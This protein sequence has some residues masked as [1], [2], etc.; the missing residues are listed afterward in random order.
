MERAGLI[1]ISPVVKLSP[2]E[3]RYTQNTIFARFKDGRS[4][5]STLTRLLD[6]ST[7]VDSIENFVFIERYG[8]YWALSGNRRLHLYK[9]LHKYGK[10]ASNKI[11]AYVAR[12]EAETDDWYRRLNMIGAP[13]TVG[14]SI[15]VQ[16]CPRCG[17][18]ADITE[19][20]AVENNLRASATIYTE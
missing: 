1:L 19:L 5:H 7:S 9:I 13:P 10:L 20:T 14:G 18:A 6:E 16:R 3:I 4:L 12:P 2:E 17:H 15:V 8:V 11:T